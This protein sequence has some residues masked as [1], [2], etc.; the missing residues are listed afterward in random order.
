MSGLSIAP[1]FPFRRIKIV[2]QQVTADVSEAHINVEPN[3]RFRPLCHRCGHKASGVHSW[4]ER[5]V[6]D[7]NLAATPVWIRCHYRKV[8]CSH[9]QREGQKQVFPHAPG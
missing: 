1:Y 3:R 7:L 5:R 6:R 4:T 8:F 2:H 9:C